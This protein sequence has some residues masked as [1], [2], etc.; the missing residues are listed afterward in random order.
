MVRDITGMCVGVDGAWTWSWR[1]A[2]TAHPL[3]HG[4]WSWLG[5][6][7]LSSRST[8]GGNTGMFK[9]KKVILLL[10]L[11]NCASLLPFFLIK[12]DSTCITFLGTDSNFGWLGG[13]RCRTDTPLCVYGLHAFSQQCPEWPTSCSRDT[14]PVFPKLPRCRNSAQHDRYEMRYIVLD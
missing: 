5:R 8:H 11:G 12:I 14:I 13:W 9:S 4:W 10:L 3:R 7:G 1:G 2:A 6:C